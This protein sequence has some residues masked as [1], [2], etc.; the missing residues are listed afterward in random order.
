[1]SISWPGQN[2]ANGQKDAGFST[3]GESIQCMFYEK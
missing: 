1:M 2:F 3:L